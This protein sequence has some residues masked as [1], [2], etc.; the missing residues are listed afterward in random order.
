[1]T[2]TVLFWAAALFIAY[3]YF[4]YPLL[5]AALASRRP[6]PSCPL[7]DDAALPRV[8]IVM[9][10]YNE[11]QR[12][13]AKIANLRA[14]DYPQDKVDIVVVSDGSDDGSLDVLRALGGVH[15]LGYAQRQGKAVALN[16]ALAAV[17]TEFVVFCDVRQELAPQAVRRLISDF[18]DPAV[19]A[20]S[21]ELVHRP[22][23]T[24]TGQ[25]IGLYWRYEKAIRKAES[26]FHSTVGATGALYAIRT[27]DFSPLAPDTIL[28]DFEIPMRITRSG[29][30]TL[31]EP[32]ALV[33]DVL[34]RESAAEKKRKIRTLSGNFQTFSR[35]FWLFSPAQNPVWLQF[36]SHK[37]FRL[38]VPYALL[39]TL[40]SSAL[41][42]APLYRLALL[43]QLGFYLLAATGRWL[44]AARRNRWVSFAE[45]FFDM[46]AA[47]IIALLTYV[48]GRASAKWE[49]T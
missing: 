40:F 8:T 2:A 46:N 12:L 34:Q 18:C 38:L 7:L 43:L 48:S 22:S 37:V 33:Y 27:R 26:R 36:V 3:T 13:P 19:G 41:L 23:D 32:Q 14:L 11:A 9:A 30:R 49:K 29:K 45:V 47:A 25:H 44:P 4:G 5:I 28:D 10:A 1:M 21:G 39:I 16:L 17:P 24:H 35:N 6:L 20:V 15:V 31:L 42:T